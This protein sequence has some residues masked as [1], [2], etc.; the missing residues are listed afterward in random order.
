M[1]L[2]DAMHADN[3]FRAGA[4]AWRAFCA[5]FGGRVDTQVVYIKEAHAKDGGSGSL[6]TKCAP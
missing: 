3:Q 1:L 2:S 6:R 4:A 5:E